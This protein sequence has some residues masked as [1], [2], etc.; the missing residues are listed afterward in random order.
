MTDGQAQPVNGKKPLTH[1]QKASNVAGVIFIMSTL[2]MCVGLAIFTMMD[3][4]HIRELHDAGDPMYMVWTLATLV[5]LV[6]GVEVCCH[7]ILYVMR[8]SSGMKESMMAIWE[9]DDGEPIPEPQPKPPTKE[10]KAKIDKLSMVLSL[11]LMACIGLLGGMIVSGSSIKIH[12]TYG[13]DELK[14]AGDIMATLMDVA[15]IAIMLTAMAVTT[16]IL[17][18]LITH[19]WCS[20]IKQFIPDPVQDDK[21]GAEETE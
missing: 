7:V 14:E 8:H 15:D 19:T 11:L 4:L 20:S 18:A 2:P 12:E 21:N 6:I 13:Y 17:Y 1:K 5:A 10:Q 3:E 9:D 16:A